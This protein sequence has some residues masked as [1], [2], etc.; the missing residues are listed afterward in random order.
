MTWDNGHPKYWLN[1]K[2]EQGNLIVPNAPVYHVYAGY[3]ERCIWCG[4]KRDVQ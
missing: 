2:D 1:M 3:P 4:H